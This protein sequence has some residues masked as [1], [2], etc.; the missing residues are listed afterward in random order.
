MI[1]DRQKQLAR[2]VKDHV[3]NLNSL[4]VECA[5]IGINVELETRKIRSNTVGPKMVDY[6][7]IEVRLLVDLPLDIAE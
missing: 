1:C 4:F 2:D 3:N 5:N 7:T 6:N